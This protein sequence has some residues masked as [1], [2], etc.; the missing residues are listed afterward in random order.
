MV[1][2]FG[3]YLSYI[4][5]YFTIMF[6][7]GF[8]YF[9]KVKSSDDYLIGGWNMGFWPIVGTVISVPGAALQYLL[10]LLVLHLT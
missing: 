10:V 7:I 5:V 4:I 9:I 1:E 6:S 3:W 8:Y 2:G